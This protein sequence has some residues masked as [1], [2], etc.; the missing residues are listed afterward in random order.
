MTFVNDEFLLLSRSGSVAPRSRA[1][2]DRWAQ[3]HAEAR[4]EQRADRTR[5]RGRRRARVRLTV[6]RWLR[7][8]AAALDGA[9][10]DRLGQR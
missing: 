6:A 10:A 4:L 2:S 3:M 8:L 7:G 1:G 9:G 5:G